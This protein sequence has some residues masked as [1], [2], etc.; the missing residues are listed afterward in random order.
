MY[1]VIGLGN[2]GK[3]YQK[4]RHNIGFMAVDFLADKLSL[5]GFRFNKKFKADIS[6]GNFE[7][8][9]IILAKPQ[10]FMNNS[11]EAVELIRS[12]YKI[13]LENIIVIYDELDLMF[14]TIRVRNSG[15]SAG[16]KGL[17]SIMNR[18]GAEK[19]S[20]IRIGIRNEKADKIPARSAREAWRG[21]KFVLSKLAM[22]DRIK[23]QK[24]ILPQV[25]AEMKEILK[26][27]TDLDTT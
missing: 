9:P 27:K 26:T 16:H 4:T 25:L 2:P 21:D 6:Q 15:S 18:I 5:P 1:L 8:Q 23:L 19:F 24:I 7:Q 22:L 11:G 14:G 3:Q 13:K 10:T 17:E 12:F 20:R